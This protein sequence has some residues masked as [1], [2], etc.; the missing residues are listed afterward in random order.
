[1]PSPQRTQPTPVRAGISVQQTAQIGTEESRGSREPQREHEAGRSVQPKLSMGLRSTRTTARHRWVSE[2]GTTFALASEVLWKTHLASGRSKTDAARC[3]QYSAN[4][5]QRSIRSV[6]GLAKNG[7]RQSASRSPLPV[8]GSKFRFVGKVSL[9]GYL[10]VALSRSWGHRGC[11]APR[12]H[13]APLCL[14]AVCGQCPWP[15]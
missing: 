14:A 11:R 13:P 5:I 12:R 9:R 2:V 4:R 3:A 7:Q 1:M 6:A 15:V 10:R 8:I